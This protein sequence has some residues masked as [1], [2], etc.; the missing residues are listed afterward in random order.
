M[1]SNKILKGDIKGGWN[2]SESASISAHE[3]LG[4]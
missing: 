2:L 4:F 3:Y 1:G